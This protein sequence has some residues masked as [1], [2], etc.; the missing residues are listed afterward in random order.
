MAN[1]F[2]YI[3]WRGDLSFAAAPLNEVDNLIL[4]T[5]SY[6]DFS[7]LLP[8]EGL[9][10]SQ[11]SQRYFQLHPYQKEPLGLLLPSQFQDLL[12]QA[13]A[14]ARFAPVRVWA[15]V[16]Q[17]DE[18]REMQF[19]ATAFSLG[20]GTTYVAFRGTDDTLVGWKEDF[21]MT[22]S[23]PVPAQ[24]EAAAYLDGLALSTGDRLVLGGHSKGGNLAVYAAAFCTPA[25]QDRIQTIWCSDSPGF[26]AQLFRFPPYRRIR[27]RIRALVPRSSVVGLLLDNDWELVPVESS[28]LGLLQ[29][30]GLTWQVMGP[31]FLRAEAISKGSLQADKTL[32]ALL[33]ELDGEQRQQLINGLFSS[34]QQSGAKTLSDLVTE[35]RKGQT[36]RAI[37]DT[38][39][40]F[41]K[42]MRDSFLRA[43]PAAFR[44]ESS[45]KESP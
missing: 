25:V 32:H 23:F 5:L 30:N 44:D 14:S 34:W 11:V 40:H 4:A 28:A 20:E 9:P 13:G 21:N 26:S 42:N 16:N 36:L 12:L 17:I 1:V 43:L 39:S 24:E 33:R 3:Q 8:E 15:H 35:G 27:E 22:V 45:S 10:L 38:L 37:Y 7:G 6:L 19:S 41:D 29:H 18:V 2:D 31:R